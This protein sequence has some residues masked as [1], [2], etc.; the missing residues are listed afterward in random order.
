MKPIDRITWLRVGVADCDELSAKG[1]YAACADLA[2][3]VADSAEAACVRF[4]ECAELVRGAD[5]AEFGA[6]ERWLGYA[7][8][9]AEIGNAAIAIMNDCADLTE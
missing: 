2:G 3:A 5:N 9:A 4:N 1:E 6:H 8:V 7:E